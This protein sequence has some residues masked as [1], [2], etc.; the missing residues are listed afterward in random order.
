MF[1]GSWAWSR[2]WVMIGLSQWFSKHSPR[3]AAL[4]TVGDLLETQI[5]RS[6]PR[7]T[8]SETLW[9]GH[10]NLWLNKFSRGVCC[11]L[12]LENQWSKPILTSPDPTLGCGFMTQFWLMRPMWKAGGGVFWES[13]YFLDKKEERHPPDI[14]YN[15]KV[16]PPLCCN[17]YFLSSYPKLFLFHTTYCLMTYYIFVYCLSPPTKM[18]PRGKGLC[19]SCSQ[20]TTVSGKLWPLTTCLL[21]EYVQLSL[22]FLLFPALHEELM[23][24]AIAATLRL[25]SKRISGKLADSVKPPNPN[26]QHPVLSILLDKKINPYLF[27]IQ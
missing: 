19:Q 16:Q 11:L 14:P 9:V 3:T 13:V 10:S 8:E 2:Q 7:P 26:Q 25:W 17:L 1:S 21:N 15:I 20:P 4:S 22:L 6:H 27:Q 23:A 12:R 5:L 18:Y 24:E